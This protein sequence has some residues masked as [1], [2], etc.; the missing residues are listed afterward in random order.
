MKKHIIIFC[1]LIFLAIMP[2]VLKAQNKNHDFFNSFI[3]GSSVTYIDKGNYEPVNEFT[4][5]VNVA[6]STGKYFFSGVQVLNIFVNADYFDERKLYN[7]YGLFTQFTVA[8][9]SRFR[10]FLEISFNK[11]NYFFPT[12]SYFPK[13]NVNLFYIGA[14]GGADIPLRRLS[15]HLFLD[16]SF[17][18]YYHVEKGMRKDFY[19]QYIVGLNYHF[20]KRVQENKQ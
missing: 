1:F 19:N 20:G 15:K 5:N 7:I 18:F 11:G 2:S 14:G 4:W 6:V 10:P 8:P 12:D 9:N 13:E 3:F 16:V 17:I